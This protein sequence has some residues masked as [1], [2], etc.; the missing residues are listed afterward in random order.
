[1]IYEE[2][3]VEYRIVD[4]DDLAINYADL[5]TMQKVN[6]QSLKSGLY[7]IIIGTKDDKFEMRP[8]V[9]MK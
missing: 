5:K 4:I 3:R 9:K 1:M 8:F 6:I 2:R 7:W